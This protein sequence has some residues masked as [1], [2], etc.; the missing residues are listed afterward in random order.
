MYGKNLKTKTREDLDYLKKQSVMIVDD[1]AYFANALKFT[2]QDN[3]NNKL[4]KITIVSDGE[5]CL[6]ELKNNFYDFIFMD[7]NMPNKNGIET[8]IE[9]MHLFRNLTI[10]AV[11]FHSEM[12][13][14]VKMIEAGA[15]SYIIKD[16][17]CKESLE[18]AI[19]IE[20]SY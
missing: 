13:Y 2:L 20:Y 10:I 7:I 12:K 11:S 9:A 4:D 18:K 3:F 14:L 16:E 6:E 5:Q 19:S 15:R 17:V 1:N 8:T